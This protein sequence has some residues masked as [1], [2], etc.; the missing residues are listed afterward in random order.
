MKVMTHYSR[1]PLVILQRF[2]PRGDNPHSPGGLWL[3]DDSEYGWRQYLQYA[4]QINPGEWH[5]AGE[6]WKCSTDFEV[7]T[8]QLLWLKTGSD[9]HQ[10]ALDYGEP[11]ERNCDNGR[12]GSGYGLHIEW[13]KV[14]AKHKGILISPYQERLSHYHG[15]PK[16]HWYRFGCASAC[17]WDSS[18]LRPTINITI[19]DASTLR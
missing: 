1:E 3:S 2:S 14:K 11:Q 9:L 16:F 17:V 4:A 6:T 10:F 18:C 13:K 8:G 12:P 15:N 19:V 5:D 7:D